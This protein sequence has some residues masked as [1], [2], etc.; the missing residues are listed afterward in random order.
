MRTPRMSRTLNMRDIRGV[1][2]V[3]LHEYNLHP[4]S[5]LR[6]CFCGQ[7]EAKCTGNSKENKV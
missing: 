7:I 2:G 5:A 4:G 1:M 6:L 3:R